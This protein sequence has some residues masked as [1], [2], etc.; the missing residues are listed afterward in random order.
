MARKLV[1]KIKGML[2]YCQ[3]ED[4][5]N[6]SDFEAEIP[7]TKTKRYLCETHA[8]KLINSGTLKSVTY[9]KTVDFD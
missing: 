1:M 7:A 4:C 8:Q 9:Q 5:W 2:G 3:A 6:K